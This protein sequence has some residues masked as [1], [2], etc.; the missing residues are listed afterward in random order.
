M[1]D[2]MFS[3]MAVSSG[4]GIGVLLLWIASLVAIFGGYS[5]VKAYTA[6]VDTGVA[7]ISAMLICGGVANSKI[8]RQVKIAMVVMGAIVLLV[9]LSLVMGTRGLIF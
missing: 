6:L 1:S 9:L 2:G 5:D 4:I 3:E 8:E 7:L